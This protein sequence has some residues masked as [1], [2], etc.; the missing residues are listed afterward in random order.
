[1]NLKERITVTS[2]EGKN[3]AGIALHRFLRPMLLGFS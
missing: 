1:M 3:A 2:K